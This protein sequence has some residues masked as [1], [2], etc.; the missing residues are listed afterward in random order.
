[1]EIL[2]AKMFLEGYNA[3][4]SHEAEIS[5]LSVLGFS[6]ADLVFMDEIRYYRNGIKYY[7][8]ILDN[9]YAEKVYT[10]MNK[11]YAKIKNQLGFY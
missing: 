2:R 8:T 7:G 6:E 1:M 9:R 3:S 4:G 11:N 5:Y 10:F